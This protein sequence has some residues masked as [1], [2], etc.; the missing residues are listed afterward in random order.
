MQSW[1]PNVGGTPTVMYNLFKGLNKNNFDVLTTSRKYSKTDDR[2]LDYKIFDF[3]PSKSVTKMFLW[4]FH[5]IEDIIRF[6]FAGYKLLLRKNDYDSLF[7][8]FPDTGSIISGYILSKIFNKNYNIYLLDLL[9]ESRTLFFEKYSLR[10]FQKKILKE[11]SNVFCV[12]GLGDYYSKDVKRK[13]EVLNHCLSDKLKIINNDYDKNTIIFAGQIHGI[14]LDA[15]Q[16]FIQAIKLSEKNIRLKIFSNLDKTLIQHYNLDFD[17]VSFH[18]AKDYKTLITEISKSV[19]LYSPIAFKSPYPDQAS[20]C[21]PTK[22]FDYILAG[23]PIFVH[24]PKNY[25]YTKYMK[26]YDS[27]YI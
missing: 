6:L 27:A 1:P 26:N 7:I 18:F 20:T 22:T 4:R 13:Y 8:T 3:T 14:S 11:A 2:N 15:L 25:F 19:F 5:F 21:F 16:I 12:E 23:R 17:F 9:S 24:A 10:F